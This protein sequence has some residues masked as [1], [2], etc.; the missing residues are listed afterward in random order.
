MTIDQRD[1][2]FAFACA[3]RLSDQRIVAVQNACLDHRVPRNF[4]RVMLT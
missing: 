4:E 3:I 1:D 2:D